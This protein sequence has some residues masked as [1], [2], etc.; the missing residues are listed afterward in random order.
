MTLH[1]WVKAS[2][3]SK[4]DKRAKD[5]NIPD[6]SNCKIN[7]LHFETNILCVFLNGFLKIMVHHVLRENIE[8][9]RETSLTKSNLLAAC[10]NTWQLKWTF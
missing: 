1:N 5:K 10:K 8:K 3:K 9:I 6:L 4:V 2:V 7:L